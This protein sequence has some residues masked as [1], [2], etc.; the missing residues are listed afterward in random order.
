[1]LRSLSRAA[2]ALMTAAT[3]GAQVTSASRDALSAPGRDVTISLLTMGNGAQVWELFGHSGMWIH[4]NTTGRDTVFNWGVFHM[5]GPGFIPNFLKGLMIYE[6]GG[7]SLEQVLYAYRYFNRSVVSQELNLTAAQKDSL[8]GMIRVNARPENIKYRY[9]YFRDN[10]STKPRDMLDQVLG[11]LIRANAT[12][13][14]GSYRWHALRLMQGDKLLVTGVD[15]GLGEPS[16]KPITKWESMFL[17]KE[18]HDLLATLQVK[19][20]T[21]A[22]RPLVTSDRVLFQA[23]RPAEPTAPPNLTPW[24]WAIGLLVGG[25]FAWLGAR[26][27]DG[28]AS[29]RR[30]AA[31]AFGAWSFIAGLLGVI[32]TLLWTVTD[33]IF[34]HAN[35]NLLLFNPGWLVLAVLLPLFVL[36]GRAAGATRVVAF[37]V[38]G[39][40]I[41]ALVAH[42]VMLSRQSNVAVIGLG[43]APSLAIAW[44]VLLSSRAR[45]R[46]AATTRDL[47]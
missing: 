38:A 17:P 29:A 3:L 39:L 25:L 32:L 22:M 15:I 21:G 27:V 46:D 34:A 7:E 20:S 33:H 19:D 5:Q 2:L 26:A 4:D 43:L 45:S 47:L 13:P 44:T 36:R 23:D 42:L 28:S 37:G 41:L 40:C 16:D 14:D 8:L 30:T 11:G 6:M 12:Q 24:L 10:C 31:I 1:M 9:D 18:L 35:E